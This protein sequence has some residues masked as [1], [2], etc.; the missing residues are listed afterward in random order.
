[1]NDLGTV[2]AEAA[3]AGRRLGRGDLPV[4]TVALARH[5]VGKLLVRRLAEGDMV[6]RV[7]ETEAYPPGD[8]AMHAYR[9]VTP[10]TRPLFLEHGHAYVYLCYG[11][12][13]MLNVASE[14]AGVGAAVLIRAAEPLAGIPLMQERRGRAGP[15]DLLRGPGR[16]AQ[17]MAIDKRFDA[18]DLCTHPTL[19]LADDGATPPAIEA[20]VRIGITKDAHR[21]LRFFARG[22]RYVSGPAGLNGWRR[23]RM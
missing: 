10:R 15:R 12:S 4:A 11:V 8:A 3:R 9:G 19:Y 1:M 21:V 13:M 17:G 20:S 23:A 16:L 14:P 5:L 22:S 18:V 2:G 6:A 7:V